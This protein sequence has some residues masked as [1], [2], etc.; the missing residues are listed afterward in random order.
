MQTEHIIVLGGLILGFAALT[1]AFFRA[2]TTAYR[3]GHEAGT[4]ETTANLEP[5]IESQKNAIATAWQQIDKLNQELTN[6]RAE[7]EQRRNSQQLAV[8]VTPTDIGLLIQAAN[9][10]ELAHRF[11]KPMKGAEPMARKAST[12]HAKLETLNSRL[13]AAATQA[14][15]EQA[16]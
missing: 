8:A 2:I 14:A 9:T 15:R 13:T 4:N 1:Y 6:V 12:Q 3:R 16:A 7:L 5:L 11:W 10:I